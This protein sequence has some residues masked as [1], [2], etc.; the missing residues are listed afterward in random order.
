MTELDLNNA[1]FYNFFK[2]IVSKLCVF[3]ADVYKV[4]I[5]N[6]NKI[7]GSYKSVSVKERTLAELFYDN[8]IKSGKKLLI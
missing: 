3:K 1:L 4:Y 5:P 8:T 7:V 2:T 6:Y